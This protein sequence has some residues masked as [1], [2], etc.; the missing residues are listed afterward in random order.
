ML[1]LD[2]VVQT[3]ERLLSPL[4]GKLLKTL[5]ISHSGYPVTIQGYLD[6]E[7]TYSKKWFRLIMYPEG[8][9]LRIASEYATPGI[10]WY[11]FVLEKRLGKPE[12]IASHILWWASSFE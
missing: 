11:N 3:L 7:L 4:R 6:N 5:L 12:D 8:Q 2:E 1:N 9:N 10:G